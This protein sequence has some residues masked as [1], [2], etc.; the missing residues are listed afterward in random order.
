MKPFES[1]TYAFCPAFRPVTMLSTM[2]AEPVGATTAPSHEL[3][4]AKIDQVNKEFVPLVSVVQTNTEI[5]FPNSDNIRHSVYSFSPAKV[6]SL[7]LYAGKSAAPVI[8]DKAGL[9]VLGCNIHDLMVSWLLVVDT[10]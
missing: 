8:F 9:V 7:K 3:R 4:H 10:P 2:F 5:T 6:F 1:S